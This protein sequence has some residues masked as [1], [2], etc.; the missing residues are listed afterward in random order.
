[1]S[2]DSKNV[3]KN[4]DDDTV[5]TESGEMGY[6]GCLL[7]ESR[8]PILTSNSLPAV[9]NGV[10]VELQYTENTKALGSVIDS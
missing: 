4:T 9:A 7:L 2:Q 3:L 5:R 8:G 10:A 1:L 6:G